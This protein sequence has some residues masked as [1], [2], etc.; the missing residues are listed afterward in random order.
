M[1]AVFAELR[2]T[3]MQNVTAS[4]QKSP[5]LLRRATGDVF[6]PLL[7]WMFQQR[8]QRRNVACPART[9]THDVFDGLNTRDGLVAIDGP[10]SLSSLAL[11]CRLWL[12]NR[13][14]RCKTMPL[15]I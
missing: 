1:A 13:R 9:T 3:I 4:I 6:H 14:V 12:E 5:G 8:S 15:R 10:G 2:V 7:I 11:R